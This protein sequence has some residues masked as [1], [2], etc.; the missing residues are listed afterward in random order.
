MRPGD[1]QAPME[2][3]DVHR[4]ALAIAA[5]VQQPA[6]TAFA[7][8]AEHGCLLELVHSALELTVEVDGL[9]LLAIIH[10]GLGWGRFGLAG[11]QLRNDLVRQIIGGQGCT[12]C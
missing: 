8:P 4:G 5:R 11:L 9:S 7:D 2:I 10:E 1:K 6:T 3:S 12:A